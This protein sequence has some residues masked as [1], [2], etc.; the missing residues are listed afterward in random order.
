MNLSTICVHNPNIL[1]YC[2]EDVDA[3][4]IEQAKTV[5]A[6]YSVI[7][8][9]ELAELMVDTVASADWAYKTVTT[10]LR[11]LLCGSRAATRRKKI[12]FVNGFYHGV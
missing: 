5:T 12:I 11:Q 7:Q 3:A 6:F 10:L 8:N 9:G 4:A 1:G 2:D